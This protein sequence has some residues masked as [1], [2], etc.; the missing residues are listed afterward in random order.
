MYKKRKNGNKHTLSFVYIEK[1]LAFS[2]FKCSSRESKNELNLTC[3][4]NGAAIIF[5][6]VYFILFS[7]IFKF[8]MKLISSYIYLL[9]I[10]SENFSHRPFGK[11]FITGNIGN[12]AGCLFC[13]FKSIIRI[14]LSTIKYKKVKGRS[15]HLR[16]VYMCHIG[17][18]PIPLNIII[19]RHTILGVLCFDFCEAF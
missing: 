11:K 19:L 3:A 17:S 1:Y 8:I 9:N 12:F 6:T 18:S 7:F 4:R 14:E 15:S 13:M 5:Y 2:Q 16:M 10:L